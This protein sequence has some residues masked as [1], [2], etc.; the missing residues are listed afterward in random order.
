M[1]MQM[2]GDGRP[3]LASIRTDNWAAPPGAPPDL[4]QRL[5]GRLVVPTQELSGVGSRWAREY[6]TELVGS[7]PPSGRN[8]LPRNKQHRLFSAATRVCSRS[9]S[10]TNTY[11]FLCCVVFCCVV[12]NPLMEPKMRGRRLYLLRAGSGK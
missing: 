8:T 12:I 9:S 1:D 7:Q 2:K 6:L 10:S 5:T 4:W 11:Y 3:Y